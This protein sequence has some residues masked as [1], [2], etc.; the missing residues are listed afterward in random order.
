MDTQR[1]IRMQC[2]PF[3]M[4]FVFSS[5]FFYSFQKQCIISYSLDEERHLEQKKTHV[6]HTAYAVR[7]RG[8]RLSL[9]CRTFFSL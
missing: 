9:F 3:N 1:D 2:L 7:L 5:S 6:T 8:I 4:F